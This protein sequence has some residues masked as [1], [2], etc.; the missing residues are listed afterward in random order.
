MPGTKPK[1]VCLPRGV[2]R[3]CVPTPKLCTQQRTCAAQRVKN[4]Q[5][6]KYV[7]LCVY[8]LGLQDPQPGCLRDLGENIFHSCVIKERHNNSLVFTAV[9]S[10]SRENPTG[11]CQY[12]TRSSSHRALPD[13]SLLA[14]KAL[15][16]VGGYGTRCVWW[17]MC[18]SCARTLPRRRRCTACL[19]SKQA[20]SFDTDRAQ[21]LH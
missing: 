16:L 15:I 11:Q 13:H 4:N 2:S 19:V 6:G 9:P 17:S 7:W 21:G 3:R 10:N 14:M 20:A 5:E 8:V 18:A 1:H 12:Y